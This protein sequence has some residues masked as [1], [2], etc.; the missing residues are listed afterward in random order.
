MGQVTPAREG[1]FF[2]DF[3]SREA[4]HFAPVVFCLK[5]A[6]SSA[7]TPL[8]IVRPANHAIPPHLGYVFVDDREAAVAQDSAHFVEHEPWILRVMQNVA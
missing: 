8:P 7:A 6:W 4:K 1:A 2:D 5:R 3:K